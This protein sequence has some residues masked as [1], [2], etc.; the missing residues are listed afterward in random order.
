MVVLILK[1]FEMYKWRCL[2]YVLGFVDLNFNREVLVRVI[3]LEII[4]VFDFMDVSM[5]I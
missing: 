3:D 4:V 5:I 1:I 2:V